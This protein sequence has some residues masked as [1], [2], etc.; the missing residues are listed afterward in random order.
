MIKH[1]LQFLILI[2]LLTACKEKTSTKGN[3]LFIGSYRLT[4]RMIPYPYLLLQSNDSLS[5][6]DYKG[7]LI[8][9]THHR[10]EEN[11]T[12]YFKDKGL[13]VIEKSNDALRVF[14]VND[15]INFRS[16]R[17]E[18]NPKY[19]ATFDKVSITDALQL[20]K[21]E[22][23]LTTGIWEHEVIKDENSHPNNDFKIVEQL[24]FKKDSVTVL[25]SYFYKNHKTIAEYQ[26]K[27]YTV[28]KVNNSYFLSMHKSG[29]NPQPIYQ[30]KER[31]KD[32]IVLIDFSSRYIKEMSYN[33]SSMATTEFKE[34][35][36]QAA[37]Y[38][39]CYDGYQGEY[40]SSD[41]VTYN[42]GNDYI[43]SLVNEDAPDV[44]TG[45]GYIVVHFNINCESTVGNYGLIQM[46]KTYKET[47]F[48]NQLVQH[49]VTKVSELSDF[50]SSESGASWLYYRDVHA[51]LMFKIENGKITDLCP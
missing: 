14:D 45:S 51:F 44:D 15:T 25:T 32:S 41:D 43:L 29:D 30:I 16:Y 17:G 19:A 39:N 28:F 24:Q 12:L 38:T 3:E 6:L 26:V 46:D 21:L 42:K 1:T 37:A 2:T 27:G 35:L 5:L 11:H 34:Q 49:L 10:L 23:D 9:N 31:H 22:S 4:D 40:Y 7:T 8:E 48:S 50:P 33:K 18:P 36:S 20:N 13:H 47:S